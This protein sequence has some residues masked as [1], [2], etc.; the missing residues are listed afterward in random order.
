MAGLQDIT[1]ISEPEAA[2]LHYASQTRVEDGS[3][4]AVYDLGGGTFDTAV[5]RKA[6]AGNF[7]LL[8]R[9]DGIETLGGADFD[10]ASCVM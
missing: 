10:A 6:G 1:L 8:G 5:L 4:V 9:P 2:A 3:I 7:E